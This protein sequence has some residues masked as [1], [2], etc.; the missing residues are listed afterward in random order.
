MNHRF[1]YDS[2]RLELCARRWRVRRLEAF[3]SCLRPD[4]NAQSDIDLLVTFAEGATW[5]LLDMVLLR[6]ELEAIFGRSV[7]LVENGSIKN[8]FRL[9]TILPDLEVLYAA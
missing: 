9:R 3:G 1:H 8:P 7:D 6:Q 2:I 4:F 5:D